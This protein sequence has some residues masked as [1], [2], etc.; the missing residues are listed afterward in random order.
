MNIQ[1][2][3]I[4]MTSAI[5]FP[6]L[7]IASL[8]H[9]FALC[10]IKWQLAYHIAFETFQRT[11]QLHSHFCFHAF[12]VWLLLFL[13]LLLDDS[14]RQLIMIICVPWSHTVINLPAIQHNIRMDERNRTI[15]MQNSS[16]KPLLNYTKN[17][18]I[19][20]LTFFIMIFFDLRI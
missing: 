14:F 10:L 5:D 17:E 2:Y 6:S 3:R 18:A 1:R 16:N 9:A 12:Y 13:F 19:S 11:L 7:W 8:M 4:Y 20:H 15:T